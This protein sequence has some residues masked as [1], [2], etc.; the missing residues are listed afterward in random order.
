MRGRFITL[1]GGEGSGKS[2]QARRIAD[3]LRARGR[4]VVLTREPGGTPLAEAIRTLALQRWDEGMTPT[5]ELLLMFAARSAHVHA[6]I[7]PHLAAGHDV[8]CDRFVDSSYAYQGAGKGVDVRH[9][10]ALEALVLPKLKPDL[11]FVLDLPVEQG[12]RRAHAR[13]QN[14]R[15]EDEARPFFERVR[16]AFLARAADEPQ[17]CVVI[18]ARADADTVFDAIVAVLEQR[19]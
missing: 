7:E 3:W 6:L 8:V 14:N 11:T 10:A 5:T 1:E 12:L 9:L 18:D 2:T 13:G 15:F 19:L 16:E 17:R 4:I